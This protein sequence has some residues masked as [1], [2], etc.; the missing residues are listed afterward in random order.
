MI[1]YEQLK[2]Y[3]TQST[4]TLFWFYYSKF[5]QNNPDS[6]KISVDKSGKETYFIENHLYHK[7]MEERYGSK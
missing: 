2:A 7:L 5:T 4:K 1:T 6:F 3:Y